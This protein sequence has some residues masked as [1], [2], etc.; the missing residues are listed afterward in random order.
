MHRF[1]GPI[2]VIELLA[3]FDEMHPSI[4]D[5]GSR[6]SCKGQQALTVSMPESQ[7]KLHNQHA[8]KQAAKQTQV[9]DTAE[10]FRRHAA[11]QGR[12]PNMCIFV[13]NLEGR[14]ITLKVHESWSIKA[15]KSL[16]QIVEGVPAKML[17][18]IFAGKQ[19]N[20]AYLLSDHNM[21]NDSTL[22]MV[23]PLRG[24]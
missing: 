22:H 14:T 16:V 19:L 18:L 10:L 15:V 7:S 23:L 4:N 2:R 11:E 20:D 21:Q 5:A 13:K 17:R 8:P 9:P 3:M 6:Q 24:D 12:S 1:A